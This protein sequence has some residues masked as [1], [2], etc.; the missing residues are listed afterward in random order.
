MSTTL[1]C[2]IPHSWFFMGKKKWARQD[3]NL[4]PIGYEPTAL[5][6]SYEPPT[7]KIIQALELGVNEIDEG[8]YGDKT[9]KSGRIV[10]KIFALPNVT[11]WLKSGDE[12]KITILK[13][14]GG[15]KW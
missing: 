14:N 3:S 6:L 9:A 1:P 5:P 15:L 2:K 11:Q 10:G 13:K 8:Q 12:G 7:G 4:R